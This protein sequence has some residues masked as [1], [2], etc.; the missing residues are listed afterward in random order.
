[1]KKLL[2][3][4]LA[5]AFLFTAT[6]CKKSYLDINA[7]TNTAT[8]ANPESVLPVALT[9]TGS[10]MITYLDYGNWMVGYQSNAGGYSYT[11]STTITYAFT[12]SSNTGLFSGAFSNLKDYNYI[13]NTASASPKYAL[14]AGVARVMKAYTYQKLV[15]E[16]GDI[17]Y[18]EAL[19]G[20]DLVTP[21][22]D[23]Q[24]V[25]YQSLITDLDAAIV[26]LRTNASSSTVTKITKASDV[27]FQGDI[28]KW[29]QFANNIKL[30]FLTRAR[31]ST[32]SAFVT[33]EF[34]TFGTEGFLK[35]DVLVNP[36]YSS[37]NLQNPI[38]G[39]YFSDVQG[40][41]TG[42]GRSRI[43]TPYIMAFYNGV[44][45]NDG[46]RGALMYKNYG[47]TPVNQLGVET[48]PT[49]IAN[50]PAW[51]IG[52]GTGA[53]AVETQGVL[54]S[55][56]MGIPIFP[57]SETYFLLA[58]AALNGYALPGSASAQA[59]FDSGIEK[60][61]NYLKKFG[62]TNAAPAGATSDLADRTAYQ[63]ANLTGDYNYIANYNLA[64][65]DAKRLEAIITQKYIA[66]NFIDSYEAWT[67]FRR[68]GYPDVY[69]APGKAA[70]SAT[71]FASIQSSSPRADRLTLRSL[72]PQ[73][74]Y[75]LNT[76][77]PSGISV[78]TTKI[79]W[80]PAVEPTQRTN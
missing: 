34:G 30:R 50:Y 20:A 80:D 42:T 16:Y 18:T 35:E 12:T 79:F 31:I 21:K 60:S 55:R 66:L 2:N 26:Q 10:L 56:V 74:E 15:D 62:G 75:N 32:L 61:Y 69:P 27:I 40:N 71:T 41:L 63:A 6:S 44:K 77:T 59:N 13:I 58:E 45:L 51:Y 70:T 72:Y 49:A 19:L 52:T 23:N 7:N 29:I 76:N 73:N 5:I 54:K 11:G 53:N 57:A 9:N 24:A 43:P 47:T 65:S 46:V 17:P 3:I 4:S 1:M 68:T 25:V 38:W 22:Y 67:E 14:F 39:T 78:F 33:T 8:S 48:G 64:N 37:T 36:G 28:T